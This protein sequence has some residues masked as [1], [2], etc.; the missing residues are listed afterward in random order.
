[1]RLWSLHP[2]YLDPKGLVA[3]WREALLAQAVLRG[4]TKGYRNHPQ[5]RRFRETVDPAAHIAEY[6]RTVHAE[7]VARGYRFDASKI[8]DLHATGRIEVPEGQI[9][10]EWRHLLAKLAARAPGR[11]DALQ[12]ITNPTPHPLMRVTP[13]NVA[14]WERP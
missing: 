10:F 8:A 7:S 14:D 9:D 3:L 12:G 2:R 6:V 11:H 1:M 13:G 4:A 5:L